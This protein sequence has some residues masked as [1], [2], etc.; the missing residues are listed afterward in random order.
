VVRNRLHSREARS[1]PW[2]LMMRDRTD[3]DHFPLTRESLAT[4]LD[5]GRPRIDALLAALEQ[6]G[7]VQRYRGG[8]RL[9][10]DA[11]LKRRTCECY[12]QLSHR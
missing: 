10:S 11:C 9:L 12:R 7:L 2:L 8:I 5:S 4:M 6:D 3:D 1:H